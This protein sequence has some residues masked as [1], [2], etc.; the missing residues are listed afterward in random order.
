VDVGIANAFSGGGSVR[1]ER[2]DHRRS[3][4]SGRQAR[5]EYLGGRWV[6]TVGRNVVSALLVVAV[7]AC[8]RSSAVTQPIAFNHKAHIDS[9]LECPF[10]HDSVESDAHAGV[11]PTDT[12]LVCHE[13]ST[14]GAAT[15][16]C[17]GCHEVDGSE[18]TFEATLQRYGARGEPVPWHRIYDLPDHVYFSH[19]RHV[20]VA[21]IECAECHGDVPNLVVPAAQPLVR[22]R[23]DWCLGCHEA[24]GASTDCIHCHR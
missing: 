15:D 24:R 16:D 17:E 1:S 7:V 10:C 23:M 14:V 22:H 20:A 13:S 9:G 12:C 21:G 5:G 19:R 18:A 3:T 8:D 2:D 11:P 6:R 4:P